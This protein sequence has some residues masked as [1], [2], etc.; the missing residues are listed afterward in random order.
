MLTE[1]ININE[2][3][4]YANLCNFSCTVG[5]EVEQS[6]ASC[7][8]AFHFALEYFESSDRK[9]QFMCF[10]GPAINH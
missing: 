6:V 10:S 8:D 2:V 1:H 5:L 9:D 3:F 4:S 7:G